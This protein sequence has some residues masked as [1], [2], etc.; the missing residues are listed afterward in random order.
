MGVFNNN[1]KYYSEKN[2]KSANAKYAKKRDKNATPQVGNRCR[3]GKKKIQA[4]V[5]GKQG[6]KCKPVLEQVLSPIRRLSLPVQ[7][8]KDPAIVQF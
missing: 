3:M 7:S 6:K 4:N 1:K 2:A 8:R 5:K